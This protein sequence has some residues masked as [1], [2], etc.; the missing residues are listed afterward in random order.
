MSE[1]ENVVT[2]RRKKWP[3]VEEAKIAFCV[4]SHLIRRKKERERKRKE[5]EENEIS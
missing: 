3:E 2:G 5:E 4:Q 1:R